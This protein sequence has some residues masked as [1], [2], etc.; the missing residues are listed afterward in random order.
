MGDESL[1]RFRLDSAREGLGNLQFVLE[2]IRIRAQH[3]EKLEKQLFAKN[4]EISVITRGLEEHLTTLER[5]LDGGIK[6]SRKALKRQVGNVREEAKRVN[7]LIDGA[8]KRATELSLHRL[9]P[10]LLIK[11]Q[12]EFEQKVEKNVKGVE[13][14]RD[15]ESWTNPKSWT[16]L[17]ELSG[18]WIEYLDYLLALCLRYDGLDQAVCQIGDALITELKDCIEALGAIAVPGRDN[19]AR[20]EPN[21]VFLRFPECTLWALPLAAHDLWYVAINDPGFNREFNR[22]AKERLP[23]KGAWSQRPS[24]PVIEKCLA[25]AFATY[26]MGPSYA[27]AALLLVLDPFRTIDQQ[28]AAAILHVLEGGNGPDHFASIRGKLGKLW[29][30]ATAHDPDAVRELDPVLQHWVTTLVSYLAKSKWPA[31]PAFEIA[32]WLSTGEAW[33]N[34][35]LDGGQEPPLDGMNLRHALSAAWV[36]R[37][38]RQQ[39]NV[40]DIADRSRK[41]C[42]SI[43]HATPERRRK[44]R[45]WSQI[46]F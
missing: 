11:N 19:I 20:F 21:L 7:A 30:H 36:A 24:L 8:R 26:L 41:L 28:R 33:A 34:A 12:E 25:D 1:F 18:A 46:P 23:D 29:E 15:D 6:L 40:T 32:G 17:K 31:S 13:K 43:I 44:S 27:C 22:Y 42:F 38:E 2:S 9:D 3:V 39:R 4:S 45:R 35:L 14:L 16:T 5:W 10:A 37:V